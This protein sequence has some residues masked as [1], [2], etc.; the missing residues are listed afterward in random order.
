M[1][2]IYLDTACLLMQVAPFVFVDATFA[3]KGGSA[4]NLFVRDMPQLSIDLDLVFPDYALSRDQA[5]RCINEAI[6]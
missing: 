2:Q 6:K 5:L 4:I 1:N 3:L